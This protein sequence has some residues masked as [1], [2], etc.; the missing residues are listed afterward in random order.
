MKSEKCNP[1]MCLVFHHVFCFNS[2]KWLSLWLLDTPCVHS[3]QM[4]GRETFKLSPWS[5]LNKTKWIFKFQPMSL[6][7]FK[8][9][10]SKSG[11]LSYKCNRTLLE[12]T[13]RDC[14]CKPCPSSPLV[15]LRFLSICRHRQVGKEREVLVSLRAEERRKQIIS[16]TSMRAGSCLCYSLRSPGPKTVPACHTAGAKCLRIVK[17]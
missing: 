2:V 15:F 14:Y 3:N 5:L 7:L 10:L 9:I 8:Y 6:I 1:S 11:M 4:R 16:L 13:A 12:S 17:P